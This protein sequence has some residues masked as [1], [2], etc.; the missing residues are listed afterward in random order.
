MPHSLRQKPPRLTRLSVAFLV[1]SQYSLQK[2]I[3]AT[4]CG[5]STPSGKAGLAQ[6][7]PTSGAR[8]PYVPQESAVLVRLRIGNSNAATLLAALLKL[9]RS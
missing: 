2:Q 3:V 6:S 9:L 7:D 8:L 5:A 4:R 1:Y